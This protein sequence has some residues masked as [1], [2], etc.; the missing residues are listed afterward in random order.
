M[1]KVEQGNWPTVYNLK[2]SLHEGLIKYV[3]Q[4]IFKHFISLY[5]LVIHPHRRLRVYTLVL[6]HFILQGRQYSHPE[7]IRNPVQMAGTSLEHFVISPF[8]TDACG[9]MMQRKIVKGK[10][11]AAP[12]YL[13]SQSM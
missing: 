12:I 9:G 1:C 11:E 10:V 2:Q 7:T 8:P 4:Y 6:W 13:Q 5:V 3:K